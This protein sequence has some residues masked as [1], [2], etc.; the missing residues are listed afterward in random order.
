[1]EAVKNKT[2]LLDKFLNVLIELDDKS[3]KKIIERLRASMKKEENNPEKKEVFDITDLAGKW[4]DDRSAEEIIKD[5]YD[6]RTIQP[7]PLPFD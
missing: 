7:D 3:K 6:S 5:I 1:M 2:S 4:E